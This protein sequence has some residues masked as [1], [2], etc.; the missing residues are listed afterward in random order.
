MKNVKYIIINI[1]GNLLYFG[2]LALHDFSIGSND[3]HI[4]GL[5]TGLA[6]IIFITPFAF[7]AI[8]T[9]F[10][11]PNSKQTSQFG[12]YTRNYYF[13]LSGIILIIGIITTIYWL[14]TGKTGVASSSWLSWDYNY[15]GNFIAY[16]LFTVLTLLIGIIANIYIWLISY[17]SLK[18]K[19]KVKSRKQRL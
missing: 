19:S 16:L 4:N 17:M 1:I 15:V 12:R 10:D 3:P 18:I 13:I 9:I 6:N 5:Q 11:V 8:I 14:I 2:L 7:Y